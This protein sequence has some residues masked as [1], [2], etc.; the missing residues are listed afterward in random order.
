MVK[1]S[2]VNCPECNMRICKN[3]KTAPKIVIVDTVPDRVAVVQA[4]KISGLRVAFNR[5]TDKQIAQINETGKLPKN[6]KFVP[7]GA[8]GYILVNNFFNITHGTKK[9]PEGFE[10]Q[11][12]VLGFTVVV[13]KGTEG[14]FLRKAEA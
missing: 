1:V 14:I 6:A 5:L 11:K 2:Q 10:L 9:L 12:N 13:P 7:N 8:G 4:P 3:R